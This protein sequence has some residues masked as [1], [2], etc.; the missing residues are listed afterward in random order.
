MD[1]GGDTIRNSQGTQAAN[2]LEGKGR[3]GNN[4]FLEVSRSG[5][6]STGVAGPGSTV[7]RVVL[8][9]R[10][11][12]SSLFHLSTRLLNVPLWVMRFA[13]EDLRRSIEGELKELLASTIRLSYI[14]WRDLI[15]VRI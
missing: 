10:V 2:R 11:A 15:T 4:A 5:T 8:Y 1:N 14:D 12:S 13:R 9:R 7:L 6:T 3:S